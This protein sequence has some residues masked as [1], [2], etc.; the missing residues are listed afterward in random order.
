MS[1]FDIARMQRTINDVHAATING[2][3]FDASMLLAL[4]PGIEEIQK[5][6]L[7]CGWHEG[8]LMAMLSWNKSW[9]KASLKRD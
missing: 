6:L 9:P 2:K 7:A 1:S 5:F 3:P 4:R 8:Q